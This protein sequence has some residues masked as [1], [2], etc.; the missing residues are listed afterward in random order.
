M[1]R[2]R[3]YHCMQV[4]AASPER[5]ELS[6]AEGEATTRAGDDAEPVEAAGVPGLEPFTCRGSRR[7]LDDLRPQKA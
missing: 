6:D 1:N 2:S 5:V 7:A 4:V 3:N